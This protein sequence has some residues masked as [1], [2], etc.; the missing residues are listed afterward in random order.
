[1]ARP[2]RD[3]RHEASGLLFRFF[4]DR[5]DS[6]RL[7]IVARWGVQP[8]QAIATY[9][10]AGVRIVWID[11]KR[12]YESAGSSHTLVWLWGDAAHSVVVVITCVPRTNPA[13]DSDAEDSS[14]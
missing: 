11:R 8:E 12:C 5:V 4:Y 13:E 1:M 3:I 14:T 9:F 7:H 6:S 2:S 10:D